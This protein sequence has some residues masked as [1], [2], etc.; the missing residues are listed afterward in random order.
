MHDVQPLLLVLP[1][2]VDAFD[3]HEVARPQ[4]FERHFLVQRRELVRLVPHAQIEPKVFP[5]I[6]HLR[7]RLNS[8]RRTLCMLAS[9]S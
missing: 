8:K 3:E 9:S 7:T 1:R 5:Q 2:T 4:M 6:L